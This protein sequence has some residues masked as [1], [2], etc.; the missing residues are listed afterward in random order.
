[1]LQFISHHN[2]RYDY[3][4]G[5]Q[6]ALEGGC[7]W[8]Q[9]RMKEATEETLLSTAQA[10]AALC[11]DHRARLIL[12][13]H[14][15]LVKA[16]GADGVHLGRNDMPVD[17]ARQ[18]LGTDYII[19]GTA[20]SIE[21]VRRLHRQGADYIGSGPYRFTTTK[22]RLAPIL[23]LEGYRHIVEAMRSEGIRLP[24]VA[25][26]GIARADILP[27]MQTGVTGVAISGGIL[28]AAN[29]VEETREILR[30]LKQSI[31]K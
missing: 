1:M 31:Q 14:V 21:D 3:I 2:S 15:E 6:M 27:V 7:R 26:G 23:G 25:I 30:L 22:Q 19:G 28:E 17:E 13:D 10:A 4:E 24:I 5:I 12:D 9:L 16:V 18:L 20:N 8:V 29:P 11:R